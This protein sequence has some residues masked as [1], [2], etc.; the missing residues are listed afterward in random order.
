MTIESPGVDTSAIAS[1]TSSS[2]VWGGDVTSTPHPTTAI[3]TAP[4]LRTRTHDPR[5]TTIPVRAA[6]GTA[7][8]IR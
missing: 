1:P 7:G 5:A 8:W 6:T 2:A 4:T 3:T